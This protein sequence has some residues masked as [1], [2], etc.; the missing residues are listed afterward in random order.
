MAER[1]ETLLS[2]YPA[3]GYRLL[4]S[5]RG[6]GG[7]QPLLAALS[8]KVSVFVGQ[9]GVGKSSII[10]R[11]LP[12]ADLRVGA[13]SEARAKG[14]HTTTTAELLH[15]PGDGSLIDS[16]GISEFGLWHMSREQVE[17]GFRE[18]RPFLGHC[19]FRDCQ[20]E[21]EPD[22]A[23]LAAAARGEISAERLDSYR[24]IVSSL[25]EI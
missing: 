13:L 18:F 5:S 12:D 22:C 21:Q 20:H 11:I 15:L 8:N 3:L 1:I 14:T 24:R 9:S 4:R 2:P 6:E 7:L 25:D 17:H 19:K 16:P 23:I 10:N